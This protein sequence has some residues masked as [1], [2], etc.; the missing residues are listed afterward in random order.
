LYRTESNIEHSDERDE[1]VGFEEIDE[2]IVAVT[3]KCPKPNPTAYN[4]KEETIGQ[5]QSKK[6]SGEKTSI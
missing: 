4:N 5:H 6:K 2:D 1:D 3:E